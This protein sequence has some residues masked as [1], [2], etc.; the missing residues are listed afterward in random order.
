[1]EQLRKLI[2][3]YFNKFNSLP[4]KYKILIISLPT[5]LTIILLLVIYI[6][7]PHY[8][9]LFTNLDSNSLQKIEYE[10]SK[11]G[12]DYKIDYRKGIIY[13]PEDK[14]KQLRILL[15][16]KGII[17]PEHR[18][19]FEIFKNPPLT[20]SD[21]AEQVN[22]LKA[23]ETELEETIESI[24]AVEKAKVNIALPRNSIFAQPEEEPRASIL[25]KLK[26][27]YSLTPEQIK[28]IRNLV[29]ASVV[30][31]KPENVVIV[32]QYGHDL[33]SLI[34]DNSNVISLAKNQLTLKLRYEKKI[35]KD[36]EKILSNIVGPG[37][38]KVKVNLYLDFRQV[39]AKKHSV[40]PDST[41]IIS[42]QKE[43]RQR[44]SVEP[45]GVPGSESNIPPNKGGLMAFQTIENSKKSITNY[46]VS[47]ID[48]VIKDPTIKLQRISI[49][50]VINSSVKGIDPQKIK[51]FLISAL[52]L[53]P[54]RG[55][56]ISV[57]VLPFKGK[58]FYTKQ[59]LSERTKNKFSQYFL[60]FVLMGI[61]GLMVLISAF[62]LWRKYKR[63]K[64]AEKLEPVYGKL[65]G[66]PA[67]AA[68]VTER[69]EENL[70][71]KLSRL[72]KENPQLYKKLLLDWIKDS[73][74]K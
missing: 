27:G 18:I 2:K 33:T 9:I 39:Q 26:P 8:A 73:T 74:N 29:V 35:E 54:K 14:V 11:L 37:N 6:T 43:K 13:V 7:L 16:E 66:A 68:V 41:A 24:E 12:I 49:G 40:N 48:E 34:D 20:I 55:D 30:G 62:L 21:F 56:T 38:A 23:L 36:I 64:S 45:T 50:V 42:Q 53:N 52:G 61:I 31:L 57:V 5:I 60:Y 59:L 58:E 69:T 70:I 15:A 4:L 67:G 22:Y 47:Y 65:V 44:K 51:Q 19:G 10:L 63:E 71:K 46:D 25:I 3:T 17:S 1:M 72:A 32:D 28:A